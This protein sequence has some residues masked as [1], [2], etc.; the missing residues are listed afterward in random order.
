MVSTPVADA[1]GS[2]QKLRRNYTGATRSKAALNFSISAAVPMVTR[3]CVGRDAQE[4]PIATLCFEHR[5]GGFAAGPLAVDQ[6]H[7]GLGRDVGI[8]F[9]VQPGEEVLAD[10]R[11]GL[12]GV[13]RP[14]SCS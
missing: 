6:D 9:A 8:A 4:R 2:P 11:E 7:V 5:L 12:R 3:T 10:L 13:G 14:G 1:S